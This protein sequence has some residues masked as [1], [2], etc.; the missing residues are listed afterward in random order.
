MDPNAIFSPIDPFAFGSG[1]TSTAT[2]AKPPSVVP[3]NVGLFSQIASA[4]SNIMN[5]VFSYKLQSQ[6]ISKG[7]TPSIA[8]DIFG[9]PSG[10]QQANGLG[11]TGLGGN[12][13][14]Y[15]IIAVVIAVLL[16]MFLGKGGQ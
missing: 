2:V 1:F 15:L 3:A 5:S 7:Q 4:G 12:M 13:L 9:R 11:V 10:Q 6:Q 16:H 14:V 8:T